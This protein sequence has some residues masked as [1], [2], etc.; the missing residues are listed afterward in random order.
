M[1]SQSQDLG[2]TFDGFDVGTLGKIPTQLN[3]TLAESVLL[4]SLLCLRIN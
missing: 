3:I 1:T 4:S 2:W